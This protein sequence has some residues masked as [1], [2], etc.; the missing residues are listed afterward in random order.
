MAGGGSSLDDVRQRAWL[1]PAIVLVSL[2]ALLAWS[3]A[4][5]GGLALAEGL[6]V[7]V[8]AGLAALVVN[9]LGQVLAALLLRM[10]VVTLR[11]GP[12]HWKPPP[13]PGAS[14]LEWVSSAAAGAVAATF[15]PGLPDRLRAR[16]IAVMLAGPAAGIL[17]GISLLLGGLASGVLPEWGAGL[18]AV[19][20]A[21][22]ELVPWRRGGRWSEGLWIWTWIRRP[23][24]AYRRIAFAVLA[25]A[26]GAG[27]WPRETR[28][29]WLDGLDDSAEHAGP[30]SA[31][32]EVLGC[33]LAACCFLDRGRLD[34]ARRW[35]TLAN[36]GRSLVAAPW[37]ARLALDLALVN[38]RLGRTEDARRR[39]AEAGD[40]HP[41]LRIELSCARA[42]LRLAAGD[43]L[44]A[45]A[46]SERGR[47]LL[48]EA[49][50]SGVAHE[51]PDALAPWVRLQLD[52]VREE[53]L[54]AVRR[55]SAATP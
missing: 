52:V 31:A 2:L 11:V 3:A 44:G 40:V 12:I 51:V 15:D 34:Q 7:F 45:L 17:L 49:A 38:A 24:L 47:A 54:R 26:M 9:V 8:V 13:T 41:Q 46:E 35:L 21:L 50:T 16:H 39:L 23:H 20:M 10:T 55:D 5:T 19:V 28:D 4:G 6:A 48:G 43:P 32:P 33:W 42:A 18:A 29:R 36:D 27:G 30:A 22:V 1:A 53:A 25:R 37:G 14:G